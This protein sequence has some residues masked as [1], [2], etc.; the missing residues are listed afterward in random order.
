MGYKKLEEPT[1]NEMIEFICDYRELY[2]DKPMDYDWI[3]QQP[4]H[5]IKGIYHGCL[6]KYN[7]EDKEQQRPEKKTQIT[8]DELLDAEEQNKDDI[9]LGM[10]AEEYQSLL[11]GEYIITGMPCYDS[12]GRLI[13]DIQRQELCERENAKLRR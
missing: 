5:K 11:N 10:T 7:N 6:N 13:N 4:L 9:P 1:K 2:T 3:V 8:I 12:N